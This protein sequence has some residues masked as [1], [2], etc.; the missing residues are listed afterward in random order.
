[1]Q[2]VNDLLGGIT[3]PD[4]SK[5]GT[6]LNP[7]PCYGT[8]WNQTVEY[9]C[10]DGTMAQAKGSITE[11]GFDIGNHTVDHLE[12]NSGW[13]G[14]PADRKDPDM[15]GWQYDENGMGPGVSM[16]QT[17]WKSLLSAADS[18]L[19]SVYPGVNVTGF[20]APRLELNDHGLKAVKEMGYQ[21]DMNLEEILL[22]NML[23][24]AVSLDGSKGEGFNWVNWPYTLDNGSPGI[25]NQQTGGDKEWVVD[26]PK[27]LWE[28]PVYML[29]LSEASGMGKVIADRMLASD[30][31]CTFPADHPEDQKDH[32]F[33]SDG[34]LEPGDTIKQVTSFDF[35]TFIYSR[36][37]KEDWVAAMKNTFLLRYHGNRAPLTFGTHPIQYTE[38]YDT[39]TL[40]Q[41]N[42]FG[43]KDVLD[44]TKFPDRQAARKEFVTWAQ[45]NYKDEVFFV[46]AKQLAD[47]MKAPYDIKGNAVDKD[48]VAE[49]AANG[50]FNRLGWKGDG[51]SI[52]VEDG[53]TADV[54]FE[55][56]DVY[57]SVTLQAGIE[58][59]SLKGVSHIDIE[60]ETDVPFRIRLYSNDKP[61]VSVLLAGVGGTRTARIRMKDFVVDAW[62]DPADI[63]KMPLV[64]QAYLESVSGMAIESGATG[65]TGTGTF[66]VKIKQITLHG[67]ATKDLC[68]N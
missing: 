66:T 21:Y 4:G 12:S 48:A 61:A 34:E 56:K 19:K 8:G 14:I 31:A 30:K 65:V 52:K 26:Y 5:A 37:T 58:A 33:L 54:T 13:D 40:G 39:G 9:V 24:A 18:L 16:D 42:N 60:Y 10:G 68:E 67:V 2:Y 50:L 36:F 3:N 57:E 49:P 46:S 11:N 20:R 43:F 29:Y 23:D 62:A 35:N 47:F 1:M 64:D 17:L 45:S 63:A 6:N 55:V 28:I 51:A 38:S 32:C 7:N 25:W 44:Y 22:Q 41:A 59:G 53:N 15:G 27:G